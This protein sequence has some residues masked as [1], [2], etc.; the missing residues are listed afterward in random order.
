MIKEKGNIIARLLAKGATLLMSC[1]SSFMA[2]ATALELATKLVYSKMAKGPHTK[3]G[4]EI[5]YST[6]DYRY[7]L[8]Y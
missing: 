1:N 4:A 2:D 3:H 6:H 8:R 7:I 5:P